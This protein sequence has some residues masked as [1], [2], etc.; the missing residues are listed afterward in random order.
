MLTEI[1]KLMGEGKW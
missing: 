1:Q